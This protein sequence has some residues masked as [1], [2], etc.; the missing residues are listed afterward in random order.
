MHKSI[1]YLI[2]ISFILVSCGG[3]GGGSAPPLPAISISAQEEAPGGPFPISTEGID[4]NSYIIITWAATN[5]STCS[6][7]GDWSGSRLV[8]GIEEGIYLNQA[9]EY[10]FTLTCQ[11][12]NSQSSSAS[13]SILANY[14]IISGTVYDEQNSSLVVY[15]DENSNRNLESF[16]LSGTTNSNGEYQI[17]SF[18]NRICLRQYPLRVQGSHLFS[19]N[20][21]NN[22]NLASSSTVENISA[23]T[24]IFVDD[25]KLGSNSLYENNNTLCDAED[26]M[27]RIKSLNRFSQTMS[28]ISNSEGYLYSEIQ[29]D[30]SSS[31]RSSISPNRNID[32]NKF[33]GSLNNIASQIDIALKAY[34]NQ[35]LA[36]TGFT[37]SDYE[38]S[39]LTDFDDRNFRIFLNDSSY[40]NPSTNPSPI[41]S[42]I[43]SI[44]TS[45]E[46]KF[47]IDPGPNVSMFN[48]NGWDEKFYFHIPNALFNNNNQMVNPA[49]SNCWVNFSSLCLIDIDV[50]LINYDDSDYDF[51]TILKKDTS[52]GS[53]RIMWIEDYNSSL[54]NC[55]I[56]A[57]HTIRE[58]DSANTYHDIRTYFINDRYETNVYD[59]ECNE[60]GGELYKYMFHSRFYP[61]GSSASIS[62]DNDQVDL[63]ENIISPTNWTTEN[64]PPLNIPQSHS[65]EMTRRPNLY[66]TNPNFDAFSNEDLNTLATFLY[67]TIYDTMYANTDGYSWYW[68]DYTINNIV[69]GSARLT[70]DNNSYYIQGRCDV[71]NQRLFDT[72]NFLS[73]YSYDDYFNST[74]SVMLTCLS[75]TDQNGI[76]V[77]SRVSSHSPERS[78]VSYSPW[79]GQIQLSSKQI[80][81][82]KN[83]IVIKNETH[84]D[85]NISFNDRFDRHKKI[86]ERRKEI[87]R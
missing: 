80:K 83:S 52:R 44:T 18:D 5:A 23:L 41:A 68:F 22:P 81:P 11:N 64:L 85:M 31:Q 8:D 1:I 79:S 9:K 82:Q 10:Q 34:L 4:V 63:L 27:E 56:F 73:S 78:G 59:E 58:V 65:I 66:D 75:Q 54:N 87:P 72:S 33:F 84:Q 51:G 38:I 67:S 69:S 77:F 26:K 48:L 29:Q 49:S 36:G 62:W 17:R 76:S 86:T 19:L 30:P 24:S 32:I 15:L 16:E 71:N 70:F 39:Y 61:N 20:P 74:I 57:D 13:V 35:G 28:Y 47:Y 40:P 37:T 53:E 6:A 45:G 43:D 2:A 46:I 50:D 25:E 3:G 12:S 7:S 21:D 14:L 60:Y 42:G 55:V